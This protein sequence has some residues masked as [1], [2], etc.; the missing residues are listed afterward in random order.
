M[1]Q[2]V[3]VRPVAHLVADL[4]VANAALEVVAAEQRAAGRPVRHAAD[5]Q[6]RL[7][8]HAVAGAAVVRQRDDGR[9]LVDAQRDLLRVVQRG[10]VVPA[11]VAQREAAG[12]R[13]GLHAE[14]I[15]VA[16]VARHDDLTEKGGDC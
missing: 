14:R 13:R 8:V 5:V 1:V 11:I 2:L 10:D 4:H 7:G 6:R 16:Q 9:L 15:A 12:Q 3:H